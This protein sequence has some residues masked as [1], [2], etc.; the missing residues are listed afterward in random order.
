MATYSVKISKEVHD[1]MDCTFAVEAESKEH[2]M[3]LAQEMVVAG[4][5]EFD[6]AFSLNDGDDTVEIEITEGEE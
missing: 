4:E 1:M 2:A 3:E 6:F 5:C